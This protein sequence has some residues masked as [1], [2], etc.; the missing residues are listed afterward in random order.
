M[1]GAIAARTL[2]YGLGSGS[3]EGDEPLLPDELDSK[4]GVKV[5]L[6]ISMDD[7]TDPGRGALHG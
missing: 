1:A 5:V 4:W 3:D 6:D 7:A 2:R